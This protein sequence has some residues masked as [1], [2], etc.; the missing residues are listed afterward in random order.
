MADRSADRVRTRRRADQGHLPG[1]A[2][3]PTQR[4]PRRTQGD[5]RDPPRPPD[6]LLL[7]RPRA[8]PL[9]RTRPRLAT[10]PLLARPPR[11]TPHAADPEARVQGQHRAA[12]PRPGA[13]SRLNHPHNRSR[14]SASPP[15]GQP[16]LPKCSHSPPNSHTS[17]RSPRHCA[18]QRGRVVPAHLGS[19]FALAGARSPRSGAQRTPYCVPMP[20]AGAGRIV[21]GDKG[22]VRCHRQRTGTRRVAVHPM[23]CV[24]VVAAGCARC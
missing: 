21:G 2:P 18:R 1:R 14:S 6:R 5:R 13:T 8:G 4:P 16:P 15:A 11:P 12:Q 17:M 3:R 20:G 7:H 24:S 23:W 22:G 9:P 19:R 10:T